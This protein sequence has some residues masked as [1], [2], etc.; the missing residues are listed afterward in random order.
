M[1]FRLENNL[2]LEMKRGRKKMQPLSEEEISSRKAITAEKRRICMKKFWSQRQNE[3][4]QYRIDNNLPLGR[5]GQ[6]LKKQEPTATPNPSS[7]SE[8]SPDLG[9]VT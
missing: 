3:I 6:R 7:N 1:L 9:A 4:L 8:L 2:E 5:L